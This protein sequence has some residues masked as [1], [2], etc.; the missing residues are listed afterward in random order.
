MTSAARM[1]FGARLR[2]LRNKRYED[3][4]HIVFGGPVGVFIA[5]ANC[6]MSTRVSNGLST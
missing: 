3:W 2:L 6:S 5:R 4:W 1:S